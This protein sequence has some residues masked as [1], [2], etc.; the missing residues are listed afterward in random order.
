M[1]DLCAVPEGEK[2]LRAAYQARQKA[3]WNLKL[4]PAW[5]PDGM[6]MVYKHEKEGGW[7]FLKVHLKDGKKGRV[8]DH[9]AVAKVLE[10]SPD[11]LPIKALRYGSAGL[12]MQHKGEWKKLD[13]E[14]VPKQQETKSESQS[15]QQSPDGKWEVRIQ[16]HN[17]ILEPRKGGE[18]RVLTS[19]G[20]SD[21]GYQG[22]L[23]A[24]D[25][26]RFVVWK[27]KKGQRRMVKMVESSPAD[28]LQP[29]LHSLRYDK[30]GDVIDTQ[31]PYVFFTD[32]RPVLV[33]DYALLKDPFQV[34]KLAWRSDSQR[35][36]YEYIERGFGKHYVLEADTEERKH[37]V[38]VREESATYIYVWG[39]GFRHD[40]NGGSEIL[41]LSE[42]DGWNHLYLLDG[43][44]GGVKKQLTHGNYVVH[45]VVRVDEEAGEVI[46]IAGGKESGQDPYYKHWYRV[47][48]KTGQMLHLTP[49]EGTHSVE[50]SPDGKYYVDSVSEV[51]RAPRHVLRRA[52]DAAEVCVL[53]VCDLEALKQT[54]WREPQPFVAKDRDGKFDIWGSVEFPDDFDPSKKYPVIENIYAGPHDQHVPKR[55]R[56]WNG[57]TTDLAQRGFIVVR[58]DGKGTGKRCREFSHFCYKNIA[59]AGFPD[60][61]AWM[62]AV[63]KVVPQMDLE[64]VGIYGGSAG[65][66]NSTGA[67]LFHGDFYKVAVSDCGCHDN[68]MDKIWWNEQWMDWPVGEHYAAQSNVTHAHK[69]KGKLLLT[70]GELD[71]NV[72]P[73]STMQVSNALMKAG[74]DHKLIV[75]PGGGHG[76]GE[77]LYP[78][79]QR[80]DWFE[81]HLGS[82]E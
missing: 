59:D 63:A 34:N 11:K 64:R 66:Q 16:D 55:F 81:K 35:L 4:K 14:K 77:G 38:L 65:G 24:P 19:D 22:V 30:P 42:R 1:Q 52:K 45:K 44:T 15:S 75:V 18:T 69:L 10:A 40:L 58:I 37:R 70:V 73:A 27:M 80:I 72:D 12:E 7:E 61:I 39:N 51:H 33:P 43:K 31:A 23:W 32:S 17:V 68:R 54:G 50:F 13:G 36:T 71:R 26:S 76:A 8:F 21:H 62:R 25:S 3:V 41:W 82:A 78:K 60:R 47:D 56:V 48:L 2:E 57:S 5:S 29:K 67:L 46:L 28:Q 79:W 20:N 49:A 6:E 53:A 9:Q 74:V